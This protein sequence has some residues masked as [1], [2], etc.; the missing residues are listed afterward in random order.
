MLTAAF[1][2]LTVL[3]TLA[4]FFAILFYCG[5][6]IAAGWGTYEEFNAHCVNTIVLDEVYSIIDFILDL[7]VFIVP[8][9]M[10]FNDSDLFVLADSEDLDLAA[11]DVNP[12]ASRRLTGIYGWRAVRHF[13]PC[14]L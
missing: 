12:A 8:L 6:D 13:F 2:S 1:I 9:P 11:A 3:W 10:V 14:Y 5:T 7:F 4:F